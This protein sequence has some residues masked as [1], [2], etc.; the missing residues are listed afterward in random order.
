MFRL[1]LATFIL[2]LPVTAAPAA[3]APGSA[4]LTALTVIT[5]GGEVQH[6]GGCRKSSPPGQCCHK[7]HSTGT[8]HCH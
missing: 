7:D 2:A 8:V 3:N 4:P 1:L 6:G 5:S